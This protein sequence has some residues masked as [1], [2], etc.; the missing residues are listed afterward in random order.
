M[1]LQQ[2]AIME[3]NR[4]SEDDLSQVIQFIN[5]LQFSKSRDSS[6][7]IQQSSE[8]KYRTRGGFSGK[9]IL[10]DDFNE[11]PDCVKEYI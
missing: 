3:V 6:T 2:Q 9:V 10:A 8:G 7:T 5:F 1:T 4:L 11:T